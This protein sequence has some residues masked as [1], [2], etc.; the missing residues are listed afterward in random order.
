MS[1]N[2]ISVLFYGDKKTGKFTKKAIRPFQAY[3]SQP[4]SKLRLL[5]N[6]AFGE[7]KNDFSSAELMNIEPGAS[8]IM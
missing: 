1:G 8:G 5:F 4:P 2:I 3:K 7:A 6:K